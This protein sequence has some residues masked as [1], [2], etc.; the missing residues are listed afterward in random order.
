MRSFSGSVIQLITRFVNNIKKKKIKR[1]S[2]RYKKFY[3]YPPFDRMY[4]IDIV[5]YKGKR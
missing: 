2:D 1:R 3:S 5:V 4:L